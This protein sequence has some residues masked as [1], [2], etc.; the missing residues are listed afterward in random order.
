MKTS[1]LDYPLPADLIAT[2]PVSARDACRLLVCWRSQPGRVEHRRFRDLPEYLKG[3]DTLVFN[4]TSVLRARLVGVRT[5]SGG[6]VGG[7]FLGEREPGV[8]QVMLR[9]NGKL[10]SGQRVALLDPA[11]VARAELE[12]LERAPE[13]W[14][15]RV[16]GGGGP[17]DVL[18]RVG[19]VPLP[20]YIDRARVESGGG[21]E[22]EEDR[23]WYQTVYADPEK[24]ASVAAPTAGLHFTEELLERV[25]GIGVSR[26]DLVLHVGAGT[27][28]PIEVEDLSEH[29]MHE[30][31]YEVPKGAAAELVA[32]KQRGG[33]CIMVGTTAVRSAENL[34]GDLLEEALERGLS[35]ATDLFITPGYGFRWVD[36]LVTNFH[37]PRSTLLALVGSLLETGSGDGLERLLE[38]YREAIAERY[39]FFSYGDA[40]LI[41]P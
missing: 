19:R 13:G 33:R 11:G 36:G 8:W 38:I 28:K 2:E 15:V 24:A 7:L 35:G 9:S 23:A 30:E 31:F 20:P 37:L 12:L 41:L 3:G 17:V 26:A 32:T 4:T 5:D 40:M 29:V 34:T 14:L 21:V 22:R 6:K 10:R 1:R 27:F 18:D 39:R 16:D 25:S